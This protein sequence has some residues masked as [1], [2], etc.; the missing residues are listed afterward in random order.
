MTSVYPTQMKNDRADPSNPHLGLI[1]ICRV[2]MV[3][4]KHVAHP[5]GQRI[6]HVG[7]ILVFTV[8]AIGV[9]DPNFF[10]Q[11]FAPL[12]NDI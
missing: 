4:I 8:G 12:W 9:H 2:K 6:D 7:A 3:P 10:I 11:C 5:G 1:F